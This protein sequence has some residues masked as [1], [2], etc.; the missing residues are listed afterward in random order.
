MVTVTDPTVGLT[1][2]KY[3][4]AGLDLRYVREGRPTYE[5]RVLLGNV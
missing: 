3:R 2:K 4:V 1:A 5:Q